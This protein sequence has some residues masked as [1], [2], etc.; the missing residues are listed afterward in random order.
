M[1]IDLLISK[2]GEICLVSTG[3]FQSRVTAAIF[4]HET[5]KMS[6]EFGETMESMDMNVAISDDFIPYLTPKDSVHMIGT[7]KTHIHEAYSIPLMHLNDYKSQN[8][9]EWV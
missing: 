2:T 9:G 6:L 5:Q 4:D 7:D 8:I 3:R 1:D